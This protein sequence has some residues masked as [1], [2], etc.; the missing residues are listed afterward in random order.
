MIQ[1]AAVA[2]SDS[3]D[4]I[5]LAV[6]SNSRVNDIWILYLGCSNHVT[7][8]HHWFSTYDSLQGGVVLIGNYVPCKVTCIGMVRI[9][10]FDGIC[11]LYLWSS[12]FVYD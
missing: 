9:I 6:A 7:P 5:L 4:S 8:N 1:L 12:C 2:H 11:I 3:E 10:M